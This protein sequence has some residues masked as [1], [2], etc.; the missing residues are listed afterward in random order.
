MALTLL[1]I[2]SRAGSSRLSRASSLTGCSEDSEDGRKQ[3]SDFRQPRDHR[4][5]GIA[6]VDL[7]DLAVVERMLAAFNGASNQEVA[8]FLNC[9]PQR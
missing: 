5:S 8:L 3:R 6:L 1:A 9:M 4:T 7:E 2:V